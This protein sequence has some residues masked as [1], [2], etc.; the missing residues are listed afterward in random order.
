MRD[1]RWLTMDQGGLSGRP[2]RSGMGS[3]PEGKGDNGQGTDD[4]S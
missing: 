2:G 3:V 1:L 4:V